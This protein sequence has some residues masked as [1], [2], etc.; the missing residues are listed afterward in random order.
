M[1]TTLLLFF[2]LLAAGAPVSATPLMGEELERFSVLAGGY[3]TYGAD[4]IVSDEVGAVSYITAGAGAASAADRVN[5][6]GMTGALNEL[7][8]ARLA[9]NHMGTGTILGATMAGNQSLMPGVYSAS[10][11]T[12]AAG[13]VLTL[14]GGGADNPFWVF[15]IP[16]YL[17]TGASTKIDVVNAGANA[18]VIWNTGGYVAMGASTSFIGTVMSGAYISDGTG[19]NLN[20]G[21]LFATSYVSISAGSNVTSTNCVGEHTWAG[22]PL[23]LGSGFDIVEGTARARFVLPAAEPTDAARVPEP[24]TITML[25]LGLGLIAVMEKFRKSGQRLVSVP[26]RCHSRCSN[27]MLFRFPK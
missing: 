6:A 13:T 18:T 3:V 9:L 5:T 21:N 20:C 14:D 23:G 2:L 22:S 16:T 11:L 1:K 24:G 25:M 10:A 12:T 7:A 19:S 26:T 4:T 8:A 15:N 27:G 17:V